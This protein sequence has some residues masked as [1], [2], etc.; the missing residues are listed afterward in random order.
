LQKTLYLGNLNSKRDWG[1]A[2]DYVE[3]QWLMLQQ[4]KPE[5]FVIA[6]GKQ[7]SVRDFINSAAKN[8][9]YEN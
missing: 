4:K 6:T 3:V 5:D 7:Y 2:K 8:L 9:E 1:H